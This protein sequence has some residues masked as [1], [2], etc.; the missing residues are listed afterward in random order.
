VTMMIVL[1]P[2]AMDSASGVG[3]SARFSERIIMFAL[4]TIYA[5]AAIY[6]FEALWP[7]KQQQSSS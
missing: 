7:A 6:L 4:A 3:A 2:A 5:V 1:A